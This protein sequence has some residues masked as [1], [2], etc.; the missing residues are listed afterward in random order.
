MK[1]SDCVEWTT[2]CTFLFSLRLS[3]FFPSVVAGKPAEG[4]DEVA[5][6]PASD[7]GSLLRVSGE[8]FAD[9][10]VDLEWVE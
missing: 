8:R 10:G 3:T 1:E 4:W 5:P 9:G 6:I 2:V 7:F